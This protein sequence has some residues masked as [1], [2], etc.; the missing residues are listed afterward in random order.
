MSDSAKVREFE[1]DSFPVRNDAW[2]L[3]S[4][5]SEQFLYSSQKQIKQLVNNTTALIWSLCDGERSVQEILEV[6]QTLFPG[7]G[8]E[9]EAD[10]SELINFLHENQFIQGDVFGRYPFPP[11]P[12]GEKKKLCIGMATYD[13]YDGVYF[14]VQAIRMYHPEVTEDTEILVIDNNPHGPC[15]E[16]LKRLETYV[17]GYRYIPYDIR[18]STAVR[19]IVF[20]EANSEFVLC[21]DCHVLLVSGSIRKLMDYFM[22]NTGDK[23]L[24]HGTL[25]DDGQNCLAT[26]MEPVWRK[27]MF[28]TWGV[29]PRGE[30][31][32]AEPF[33]IPLHGAGLFACRKDAWLGFNPRFTQFGGEEGYIHEKFRQAGRRVLCLP[34]L[35]WMHRFNRPMGIPYPIHWEARIRN[36]M[37]GAQELGK[38]TTPIKHH[39]T[40]LGGLPN[41]A[42]TFEEI[43]N[44]ISSPF[45]FFDAIYCICQMNDSR[46]WAENVQ[47]LVGI[48]IGHRVFKIVVHT[49]R[50]G[51]PIGYALSQRE[52]VSQ[53][54]YHGLENVLV[55][56][57]DAI[58]HKDVLKRLASSLSELRN[59][60]WQLFYLGV[61]QAEKVDPGISGLKYLKSAQGMESTF[62]VAFHASVYKTILDDIPSTRA[63]MKEWLNSEK[64]IG[65][66]LG[67]QDSLAAYVADPAVVS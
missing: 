31:S 49:S 48:G 54:K 40:E 59:L 23:D 60:D 35:R 5:G 38:D 57:D 8:D 46:R 37:I 1:P 19:D 50:S 45:H 63:G 11:S 39:F 28:G 65:H 61:R 21:I 25:I 3:V 33:D 52:V 12:P 53:A 64:S 55:F 62:A 29:D 14:S 56:D 20:R 67:S 51:H 66:Y 34:F 24:L 22:R 2:E 27:G 32:C 41:I 6:L 47:R 13:D 9:V 15:A 4:A 7:E 26:H 17:P 43:E 36:Y 44:E 42:L 16:S 10:F 30:D 18:Q 58:F